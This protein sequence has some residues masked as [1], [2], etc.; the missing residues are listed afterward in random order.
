MELFATAELSCSATS[1][2]NMTITWR[3]VGYPLP[4]SAVINHTIN[5][6]NN[7]TSILTIRRMF[8]SFFGQYYCV[9]RNHIGETRS[10]SSNLIQKSK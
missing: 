7:V 4:F 5:S 10:T 9:A 2:S 3:R 6:P 1:Y 8:S